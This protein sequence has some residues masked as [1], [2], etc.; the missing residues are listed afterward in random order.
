MDSYEVQYYDREA[1]D[2]MDL[3]TVKDEDDDAGEE[4]D[5]TYTHTGLV[6]GTTLLYR[7][8][9]HNKE[10]FSPWSREDAGSTAVA[11]CADGVCG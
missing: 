7:V 6:G 4:I 10:G 5:L 9:A 11:D 3:A 8:R 2:W 1:G